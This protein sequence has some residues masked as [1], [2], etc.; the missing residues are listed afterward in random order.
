MR[1]T[2]AV[3]T[4]LAR[5]AQR[6]ATEIAAPLADDIDRDARFPAEAIEAMRSEAL[7]SALVPRELG[8]AGA[9]V[10]EVAQMT[11]IFGV[12]CAS[13]SLIFAM[14]HM[15]VACLVRHGNTPILRD[16]LA[17]LCASQLLL[18]SATTEIGVGGDIRT[19]KCAVERVG[20]R[21]TLEKQAPVISY[22]MYAD[23]IMATARRCPDSSPADQVLVLCTPPGLT[24]EQ[25]SEWET[26]GF[27]GTC[28]PGFTLLASGDVGHVLPTPFSEIAAATMLPVGHVL[29]SSTWVGI[30]TAAVERARRFVRAEAR[31]KPGV[32]PPG[33]VRLAE[34]TAV[35]QEMCELVSGLARRYDA[36]YD[37]L[38][39]L[40]T[41]SLA[42][43]MNNL[44]VS[45]STMVVDIVGRALAICGLDGYRLDS[46][47][48]LGRILRDAYGASLMVNNDRILGN[49]AQMLLVARDD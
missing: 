32:T 37:D 44:K 4:E 20:D 15:Q 30:A 29:W 35:H 45:A 9:S 16:F 1:M 34:L 19:S 18:A 49:T 22:G 47:N 6:I 48:T 23:A 17:E 31:K 12:S 41:M 24:L 21:F 28:S 11:R 26:L 33:A 46:P 3:P 43:A 42:I 36:H 40:S 27:R 7:L 8:G 13:T 39:A 38:Q 14:H 5:R 25:R 2:Q 10:G